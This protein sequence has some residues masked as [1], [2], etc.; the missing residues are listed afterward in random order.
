MRK[1]APS[2]EAV[3]LASA[4]RVR[5]KTELCRAADRRPVFSRFIRKPSTLWL[6]AI[7]S[8]RA[9]KTSNSAPFARAMF[10]ERANSLR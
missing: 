10:R 2:K 8:A 7:T 5:A 9:G 3:L 1:L 6:T 4:L